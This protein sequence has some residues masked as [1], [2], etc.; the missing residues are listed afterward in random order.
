M[1]PD[2]YVD[3]IMN[4]ILRIGASFAISDRT[5]QSSLSQLAFVQTA[6]GYRQ[7]PNKLL[8]PS[9]TTLAELYKGESIFPIEPYNSQQWLY[10]LR[11]SCGLRTSV[12]PD[13]ILSIISAIKQPARSYS[14]QVSQNT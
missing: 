14:Q 8:D 12:T 3:P 10:F 7:A 2:Q 13:E 5:F 11:Q 1:I 6:S 4:E 9:N